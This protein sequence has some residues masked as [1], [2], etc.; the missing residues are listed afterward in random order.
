MSASPKTKLTQL[1]VQAAV[2]AL[3]RIAIVWARRS[4]EVD[5]PLDRPADERLLREVVELV[6]RSRDVPLVAARR[7]T[8]S[9]LRQSSMLDLERYDA[10]LGALRD[11][12]RI[13]NINSRRATLARQVSE[14]LTRTGHACDQQKAKRIVES[15]A[16][17]DAPSVLAG[18]ILSQAGLKSYR[19]IAETK[20][21]L[22]RLREIAR[23]RETSSLEVVEYLLACLQVPEESLYNFAGALY[24]V[25]AGGTLVA[26]PRHPTRGRALGRLA[27]KPYARYGAWLIGEPTIGVL[28]ADYAVPDSAELDEDAD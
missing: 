12:K 9:V 24:A 4:F 15:L 23:R 1:E 13:R 28:N 22:P 11:T 17:G 8:K 26:T 16:F 2:L 20:R 5:E 27:R 10:V 21:E 18:K 7:A 6:Q 25:R 3:A 14:I 19:S